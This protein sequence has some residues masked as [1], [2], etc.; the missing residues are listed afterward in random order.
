MLTCQFCNLMGTAEDGS[1]QVDQFN[2]GFWCEDCDGYTYLNDQTTRH[3]FTLILEDKDMN[4]RRTVPPTIKLSKQLSPYRYPGGKSKLI[5][6]LYSHLQQAKNKKLVSPFT[7]GGSFEL[8]MLD[9]GIVEHLHLNDLDTGVYSLWWLIKYMPF[10]LIDRIQSK[11]P[12]HKEFF[13]A[14]SIIKQDYKGIDVVDAAWASLIVNRLA[15][16]GIYKANPLGGKNG[17]NK[18]LLSRWN[19]KTLVKRIDHL[20]SLSD[21]MTI[22]QLNACELIE[23]AYWD[24]ESTLFIDPPYVKKG[25]ELYHCYY[26]EKDHRELSQL[27]NLLHMGM[28]GADLIVTYDYNEWINQLYDYPVREVIGRTYSC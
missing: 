14:Q 20:H 18:N 4:E 22:T 27:L 7:G 24:S 16:S 5:E 2:A 3:K 11:E 23:E 19:P 17:T 1:F 12:T 10:A 9:A 25:K 8:A 15:Y 26:S 21:R 28:P 6:Y 13:R